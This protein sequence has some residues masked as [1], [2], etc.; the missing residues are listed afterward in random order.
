VRLAAHPAGQRI[1]VEL[2]ENIG[3]VVAV[4][5]QHDTKEKTVVVTTILPP[6]TEQAAA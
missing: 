2:P 5:C 6:G 4:I 3:N 1:N